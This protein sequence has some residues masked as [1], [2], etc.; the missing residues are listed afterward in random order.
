MTVR[1]ETQID[2]SRVDDGEAG[3]SAYEAAVEEGYSGT[4]SQFNQ[5]L[6]DTSVTKET[7]NTALET[8]ENTLIFDVESSIDYTENEATLNVHVYRGGVDVSRTEF[9]ATD[10]T[11]YL[12]SEDGL[13]QMTPPTG[14][15]K[16]VSLADCGYGSEVVTYFTVSD[17]SELLSAEYDNLQTASNENLTARSTG[18]SVRVRD[19]S[20][21]T[22][23]YGTDRLMVAGAED[24]HLVTMQTLQDYLNNNLDKQ[25]LFGTT[26]YWNAQSTLQSQANTLYIYTDYQ[27]VNSQN[28]AGIKVG[29]GNAYLI[30]IPFTDTIAMN[31]ISDTTRHITQAEREFWN[32]KVS[33]YYAGTEQLILTTS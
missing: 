17:D 30:D 13:E 28:V 18:D 20:V 15:T 25:V 19:L 7:A 6:A 14:Y 9:L 29:D 5:D 3:K 33:A 32:N 23:I 1:A 10:F 11:W 4:E 31:H 8:A 26:A 2:L 21:S 12:K 22:T 27:T 16:T 24:E